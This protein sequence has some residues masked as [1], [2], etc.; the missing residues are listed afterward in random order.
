MFFNNMGGNSNDTKLYETL[1]VSKTANDNEIRKAYRKLAIKFHP[2]K[3]PGKE[4]E[5]KFKEISKAYDVLKDPEKRKQYDTFG[6][7]A[8]NQN[9]PDMGSPFDMFNDIFG[10]M[11]GMSG[12]GGM[13]GMPGMSRNSQR[14]YKRGRD[15]VE[16]LEL[17]LEDFYKCKPLNIKLRKQTLCEC[18]RGTGA[19]N[20]SDIQKC[21][22]CDGTGMILKIQTLGPGII[23][24]SQR[25]CDLCNGKGKR[26]V[27]NSKC[28]MCVGKGVIQE[29][30]SIKIEL[31]GGMSNGEKVVFNGEGN[32][33]PGLDEYGD[34]IIILICK[35]HEVFTKKKEDLYIK[36][37]ISLTSALCGA[38][39]KIK[40]LDDRELFIDYKNVIKPNER[41]VIKNEGMP[42]RTNGEFGDLYID[43]D[44]EFPN[45]LGE[46]YKKYICKL[47]PNKDQAIEKTEKT[48]I[49]TMESFNKELLDTEDLEENEI[50]LDGEDDHSGEPV[51]CATQ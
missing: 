47:I 31:R 50:N 29:K 14:R 24:Q 8:I 51:N 2:D 45:S 43:F 7:D 25:Q 30:K 40:H 49:S 17:D 36:Q 22:T 19:E 3:N 1:G 13:G 27:K 23:T 34:L 37:K 4:N 44:I 26:N 38:N 20:P 21:E 15:R 5:E 42:E 12:M 41:F 6:L 9:M 33:E 10:G 11:G 46:E 16:N 35:N 48:V 28:D 39:F 32:Q 18:C